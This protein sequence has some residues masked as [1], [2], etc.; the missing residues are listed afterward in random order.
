MG[1]P[2]GR[3]APTHQPAP[4][5]R[6]Y[7][8]P[9]RRPPAGRSD[10]AIQ[11]D[12]VHAMRIPY[13]GMTAARAMRI[14]PGVER[15][16]LLVS[17]WAT[18]SRST[19]LP[20]RC[21]GSLTIQT[22]ETASALPQRLLSRCPPGARLELRTWQASCRPARRRRSPARVVL[23]SARAASAP[24][25]QPRGVRGL[26][27]E[28]SLLP[29][30]PPGPGPAPGGPLRLHHHGRRA[31]GAALDTRAGL[32]GSVDL[33]PQQ[34]AQPDG[35]P[36]PPGAPG[37]SP[38]THDGTPNTLLKLWPAA[39]C[40]SPATWNQSAN[41]SHPGLTACW[42]TRGDPQSLAQAMLLGFEQD[43]LIERARAL[44]ISA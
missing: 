1:W 33:L 32:Q 18:I 40:L 13:E 16:P 15:P 31:A 30:H 39:A 9:C 4:V 37:R 44:Q 7:N 17:I 19:H 25:Y 26:H 23:F 41:G 29:L 34:P 8:H 3:R 5:A 43:G 36:L 14:L 42:P 10:P 12:L 6:P 2:G 20:R 38:S 27:S 21:M 24:G 11:P 28:R 35:R 22:L